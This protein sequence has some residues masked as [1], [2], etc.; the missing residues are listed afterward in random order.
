M[1]GVEKEEVVK[2][3]EQQED[4]DGIDNS[5]SKENDVEDVEKLMGKIVTQPQVGASPSLFHNA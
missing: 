2:T 5:K 4:I 3:Q 1:F